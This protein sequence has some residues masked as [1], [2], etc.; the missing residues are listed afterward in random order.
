MNSSRRT[1]IT[2]LAAGGVL[3][4]SAWAQSSQSV[5]R[6]VVPFTQGTGMDMVARTIGPGLGERLGRPAIVE[7]RAGASGN[8][9][10]EHVLQAA[11]DGNTLL[12]SANTLLIARTLYPKL[13]FDPVAD[14][15][16]IALASW[17]QLLLVT[18]PRTGF[19]TAG[20]LLAA[21]RAKPGALNYASPGAGTPHHMSMEMLKSVNK[22]FI[23][24]IAYRGTAPAVQDM[25]G[26]HVDAMF[27]PIHV[28][29]PLIRAGRLVVLGLGGTAR[30]PLLP[31][32]PTLAEA[33]A[34]EVN[35]A[36]WYGFFGPKGMAPE[37]VE[38]LHREINQLLASSETARVFST[39]G[40]DPAPV[41]LKE[42]QD[43]IR[44][45]AERWAKLIQ[46]QRIT[47]D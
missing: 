21:A 15:T 17:G 1:L 27:M 20:D 45:D 25:V 22:V 35:V 41:S 5:M 33:G 2:A 40:M 31:E 24:H 8:I 9:G 28:A 18:H 43:L 10:A 6:L 16:P 3:P 29:L 13:T 4:A 47:A 32:V 36:M 23:T 12:V 38:R 46:T 37:L 30:H 42:Y 34:G 7:N 11:P 14:F 19:K 44:T 39:Q 26:G